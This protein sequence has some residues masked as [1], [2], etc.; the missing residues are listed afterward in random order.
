MF[1]ILQTETKYLARLFRKIREKG[2]NEDESRRLEMLTASTYGFAQKRREEYYL[3]KLISSTIREEVEACSTIMDFARGSFFFGRLFISYARAPR[4]RR[5]FRDIL[6]ALVR[7]H[8]VENR[9][10]DI[11]SDPLQIYRAA[12]SDEELQT[13][14]R[15]KRNPDIP[16][17]QAIKDPQTREI[18]IR[19]LQDLRDLVDQFLITLDDSLPRLPYGAR[20]VAQQIFE[21]LRQAFPRED[22]QHILQIA[23]NWLWKT[24]LKPALAEP[25]KSGAVDRGLDSVQRRNL[26]EFVKVINKVAAGKLFRDDNVYLQP[27]NSYVNEA[28]GRMIEILTKGT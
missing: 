1:C 8:I 13:G 12:I 28:I 18:F 25:E 10:L 15:S 7:N 3:L 2:V 5:Y 16:R 11:E 21:T 4:D 26:N 23:G 17:E 14:Q 6:G 9:G 27:L 19:H 22:T 24:Y 20:F